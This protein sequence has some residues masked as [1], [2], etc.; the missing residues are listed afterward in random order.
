MAISFHCESCKKKINAPDGTGGKWGKC[1]HCNHRCYIPL[2]KS[3][4]E[5]ELKLAPID[6]NEEAEYEKMMKETQNLKK[7]VLH[8]KDVPPEPKK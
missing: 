1:P 5:E 7:D 4:D 3:E 8:E 2:P 6:P